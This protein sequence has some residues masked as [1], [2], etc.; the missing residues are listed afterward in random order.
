MD[1]PFRFVPDADRLLQKLANGSWEAF[2]D[3]AKESNI[4]GI[5]KVDRKSGKATIRM[6]VATSPETSGHVP[7]VVTSVKVKK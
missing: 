3:R 1:L 6:M 5:F 7:V 2:T 4:P